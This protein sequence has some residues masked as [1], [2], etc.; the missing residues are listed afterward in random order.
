MA[1]AAAQPVFSQEQLDTWFKKSW[2]PSE[3]QESYE[4][5]EI[6]GEIPKDLHGT[7]YRNG[8]SQRIMPP[9]G[10][11]SLHL[12][13]GDALVHGFRFDD[14]KAHYT[15]RFVESESYLIEQEAGEMVLGTV[16]V[17]IDDPTDK[18]FLREQHNTNI[19]HHGGKLMALVEN[20][21]PFQLDERTLESIGKTDFGVEQLGMSV[22]AHP[23]IDG[24]TGQMIIHGY[25][26]FEPYVQLYIVEPD[27]KASLAETLDI[28]YATM[29][30]DIAITENYVII[31]LAPAMIDGE[32]L[33]AGTKPF[34]ECLSWEPERGLKFGIRKRE[35]GAKLQW[36]DAPT[37]GF[38]FH[39]GN[40]YE[41]DGKIIMDTCTYLNPQGLF[42]TLRTWRSGG[43]SDR[44]YANPFSYEFDL[45]TG[46]CG[47]T[48]LDSLPAEFP[49][50]DDRLV[51]YPNRYGYALMG[52][53]EEGIG[54]GW[55][56][57]VRYDRT[58]GPNQVHAWGDGR[59]ASEPVF[60]ARDADSA[61]DEGYVLC[62]VY[63]GPTDR[64]YVAILDARN[65]DAKP[66]AK[67]YLKHRIP[68]GFHGNFAPGV[69]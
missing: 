49:R 16:N 66:L 32:N 21:W 63:D 51:G 65:V 52:E 31:V 27:G 69:V 22:T 41:R 29:M 45:E 62:T 53:S 9:T 59:Y 30:H 4:I 60:A 25:Q 44:W 26:P 1:T 48:R 19:V 28:P 42:D 3:R 12:F 40:A 18:V 54:A 68:Q 5:T 37:P 23:K 55:L 61:E 38:I 43:F 58:G 20:S 15:G 6:E 33:V 67:A 35:P 8:P 13:D 11:E 46:K 56:N 17:R 34:A 57:T 24:K 7:L 36:F 10:Y 47:E 50:L 14:G 64:S 2:Y 39:P